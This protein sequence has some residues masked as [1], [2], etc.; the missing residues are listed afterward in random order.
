MKRL[1]DLIN[2]EFASGFILPYLD[3]LVDGEYIEKE[4]DLTLK[5]KGSKNQRTIN[6]RKSLEQGKVVLYG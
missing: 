2:D 3:V 4:R 6:V 1:E 5:W